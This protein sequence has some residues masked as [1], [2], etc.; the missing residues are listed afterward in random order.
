MKFF[1]DF[2]EYVLGNYHIG[3]AA[4]VRVQRADGIFHEDMGYSITESSTKGSAIQSARSV[5][6]DF[7]HLFQ[8]LFFPAGAK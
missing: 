7:F 2:V 6:K 4:F 3:C 1:V 5:H 8:K